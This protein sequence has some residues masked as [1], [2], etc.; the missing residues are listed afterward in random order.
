VAEHIGHLFVFYNVNFAVDVILLSQGIDVVT[1]SYL[2]H[3]NFLLLHSRYTW[4][5]IKELRQFTDL[6]FIDKRRIGEVN[7]NITQCFSSALTAHGCCLAT[8]LNHMSRRGCL[9]W[10]PEAT[11]IGRSISQSSQFKCDYERFFPPGWI[12]DQTS[13]K[14]YRDLTLRMLAWAKGRRKSRLAVGYVIPLDITMVSLMNLILAFSPDTSEFSRPDLVS[15]AQLHY[16]RLLQHYL[17]AA[18]GYEKGAILFGQGMQIVIYAREL[19]AIK[20]KYVKCAS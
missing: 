13:E 17:S 9:K 15:K 12:G 1:D 3:H 18:F 10:H 14:K 8:K 16:A 20:D 6:P 11:K 19:Q 4:D 2:M 7:A 5:L